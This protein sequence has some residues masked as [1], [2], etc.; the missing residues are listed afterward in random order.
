VLETVDASPYELPT[1]A[2]GILSSAKSPGESVGE[3]DELLS[4]LRAE[5]ASGRTEQKK[6]SQQFDNLYHDA[7]QSNFSVPFLLQWITALFEK[8]GAALERLNLYIGVFHEKFSKYGEQN[9]VEMQHLCVQVIAL[10]HGWVTPYQNLRAKLID[11]ASA[12]QDDSRGVLRARPAKGK[13][14]YTELSREHIARYPKI[15]ARLAE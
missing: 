2:L 11:L 7:V 14:D 1:G 13:I 3:R 15:R 8:E 6:W 12:Q 4:V 9:D 10:L 5:I